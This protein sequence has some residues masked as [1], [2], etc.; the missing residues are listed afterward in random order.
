MFQIS[1]A[2]IYRLNVILSSIEDLCFL[3]L[4]PSTSPSPLFSFSIQTRWLISAKAIL[5]TTTTK[6]TTV[7]RA[8]VVVFGGCLHAYL[9]SQVHGKEFV[10]TSILTIHENGMNYSNNRVRMDCCCCC[11]WR[12]FVFTNTW[13]SLS[14]SL[15]FPIALFIVN[16]EHIF[17]FH[18]LL[19][20]STNSKSLALSFSFIRMVIYPFKHT[21]T[22]INIKFIYLI[23]INRLTNCEIINKP[24]EHQHQHLFTQIIKIIECIVIG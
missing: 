19:H 16:D 6:K 12:L 23:D 20:G 21:H 4:S 3:S 13:S 8:L 17:M 22:H 15:L 7:N 11:C 10:W 18:S 2:S 14:F 24:N 9:R 5:F 1:R